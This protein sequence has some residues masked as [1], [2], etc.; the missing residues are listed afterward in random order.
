[1]SRRG[2]EILEGVIRGGVQHY[3]RDWL[4]ERSRKEGDTTY[5]SDVGEMLR[6]LTTNTTINFT[7]SDVQSKGENTTPANLDIAGIPPRDTFLSDTLLQTTLGLNY[8]SLSVKLPR[9]EY[10]AYLKKHNFTLVGTKGF[11]RD[12][13]MAYPYPGSTYFAYYVPQVPAEDMY[14]T[15]LLLKSKIVTDKFVAALLMVDY[16][17][18]LFSDKRASLQKYAEKITSGTVANGVSSIPKDFAAKIKE[19]GAKACNANN[20]DACSAQEQFLYT[21]ELP[22]EQWKQL[23]AK[24]LQGYVD[25]VANLE[26]NERLEHLMRQSIEQ[27]DRV[28]STPVLCEFFATRLMFPETDLSKLSSCP[29]TVAH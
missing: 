27:R 24:R 10:D 6:H 3:Y 21:W 12:T 4:R 9:K 23:T 18:P 25:S 13:P 15:Q 2:A 5:L 7:S 1:L 19:T 16:K 11:T 29:K 28:S 26:P 14:V 17:N 8:S 22:D 20:F